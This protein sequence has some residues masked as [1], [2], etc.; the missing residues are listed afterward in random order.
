MRGPMNGNSKAPKMSIAPGGNK[1]IIIERIGALQ[2]QT[3]HL[4]KENHRYATE[5]AVPRVEAERAVNAEHR[6]G[7]NEQAGEHEQEQCRRGTKPQ[8]PNRARPQ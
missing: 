3:Q 5:E 8:P 2:H 6:V 1:L 4:G 7:V